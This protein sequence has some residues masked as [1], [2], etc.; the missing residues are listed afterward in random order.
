MSLV[1]AKAMRKEYISAFLCFAKDKTVVFPYSNL[2][3]N[4]I[5]ASVLAKLAKVL[6]NSNKNNHET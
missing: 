4:K 6:Q 2:I 3:R 5:S 1:N